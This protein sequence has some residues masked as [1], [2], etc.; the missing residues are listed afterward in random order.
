MIPSALATLAALA[1]LTA[2]IAPREPVLFPPALFDILVYGALA[3]TALG[4]LTLIGL[5]LR[6]WRKGNTW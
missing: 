5:I 3:G 2:F 6:D 4:L 1:T